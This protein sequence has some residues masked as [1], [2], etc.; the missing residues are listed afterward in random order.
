VAW[1][2]ENTAADLAIER[3]SISMSTACPSALTR[4]GNKTTKTSLQIEV[5]GTINPNPISFFAIGKS[6]SEKSALKLAV[7]N[8]AKPKQWMCR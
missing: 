6:E 2:D 1:R 4:S 8:K 3:R 7:Q 5:S